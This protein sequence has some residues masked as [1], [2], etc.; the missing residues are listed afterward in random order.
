MG[1]NIEVIEKIRSFNRFYTSVLGLLNTN[2]LKSPY[3]LAEARILFELDKR[4]GLTASELVKELNLDSAYLSRIIK[5]FEKKELIE[6]K[7]SPDD[8]RKLLLY[9]TSQGR[10]VFTGLQNTSNNQLAGLLAHINDNDQDRL[11]E[12]M[13]TIK[14]II[15]HET[16]DA[17]FFTFRSHRPGDIGYVTFQHG[18]F[19]SSEYG[20]DETFDAYVAQ[21]LVNFINNFDPLKEH[22]WIVENNRCIVGSI[23]IVKK[24]EKTAQ[25]RWFLV[26]PHLQGRGIGRK[27]LVEAINFSKRQRYRKIILW[28]LANLAT[29]RQ[30]YTNAD[31]QLTETKTHTVWGQE[32]TEELWELVL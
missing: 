13:E 3:S 32:L 18:L 31:F 15:S 26:E 12:A 21:G 9:L 4:P 19:Y 6:K 24:D 16:D 10:S 23:A 29:A 17:E 30:L 25:L 28:T 7:I 22:L 14:R 11:T 2:L 1:K 8:S 20:F 27:L 5:G